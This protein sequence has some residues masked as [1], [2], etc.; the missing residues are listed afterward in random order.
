VKGHFGDCALTGSTFQLLARSRFDL[1]S[2]G[3]LGARQA[4]SSDIASASKSCG[5]ACTSTHSRSNGL[6][7]MTSMLRPVPHAGFGLG[8]ARTL[9]YVTGLANVRDAIPFPRTSGNCAQ[10][11][12]FSDR[13]CV[14]AEQIMQAAPRACPCGQLAP[15][16]HVGASWVR[17]SGVVA[18]LAGSIAAQLHR[19]VL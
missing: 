13:P 14:R 18:T 11:R 1:N 6:P 9:A 15:P 2:A 3:I 16:S 8:F 7:S 4:S 10:V 17:P 19:T 12:S 5:V